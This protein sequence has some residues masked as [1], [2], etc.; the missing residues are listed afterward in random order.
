M[1]RRIHATAGVIGFLTILTFWC[2]TAG[3]ELFGDHATVAAAKRG[4]LWGMLILVPSMAVAGATGFR[5]LN[6]KTARLAVAKKKRMLVVGPNG[7]L[8]LIPCAVYL[9]A[10]A[11]GGRFTGTFYAVQ[12]IELIAGLVNLT[13]MALNIRDGLRLTGRLAVRKPR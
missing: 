10:L 7:L 4:I 6:G 9:N 13:L 2:S 12:A 11:A 5:L 8:V 1:I 3:S